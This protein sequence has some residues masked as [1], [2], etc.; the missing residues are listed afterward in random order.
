MTIPVSDQVFII[1][2]TTGIGGATAKLA[3]Q[4]GAR[5]MAVGRSAEN[6]Q[7]LQ[8][9]IRSEGGDC[10]VHAQDLTEPGAESE[11]IRKTLENYGRIDGLFYV[12]GISGRRWGD[13]PLHECTDTGWDT[14]MNTNLRAMFRLNRACIQ[15]WLE[16]K[17]PGVILN[18]ASVLGFSFVAKHF[19][20][21]GYAASKG[22]II[23]MS[24]HAAATY[25]KEGIRI[26]VIAPG[27]VETP[28]AQRATQNATILDFIKH[29]QPL[30]QRPLSDV[31][32]AEAALF[33]LGKQSQVIT[34]VV[35]PV[36]A[37]WC[38]SG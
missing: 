38:V 8:Q 9:S 30:T 7:Q 13:G 33:L 32:V 19:D 16:S 6:A 28:M 20:A 37:G 14:I 27:L 10:I 34:G 17:R 25:A 24:L 11:V 21:V 1:A 12:A 29:K 31:E 23:A 26:N 15:H 36:D 3:A 4:Q 2:G 18:M 22:A 35:L 5:I